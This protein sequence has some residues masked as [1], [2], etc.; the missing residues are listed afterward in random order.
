MQNLPALFKKSVYSPEFYR[1]LS[2]KPFSFSLKY[3][4]TLASALAAAFAILIT[5]FLVPAI[6]AFI[7]DIGPEL[8]NN[9]PPIRLSRFEAEKPA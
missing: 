7:R 4:Y 8:A 5:L 9:F 1:E 3:F 6:F 2:H